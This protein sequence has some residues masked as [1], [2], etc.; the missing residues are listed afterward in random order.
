VPLLCPSGGAARLEYEGATIP[1]ADTGDGVFSAAFE[2][3]DGGA[4]R[5]VVDCAGSTRGYD[6][7]TVSL[8]YNGFI[9]NGSAKGPEPTSVRIRGAEVRLFQL[10]PG[11]GWILW[12]GAASFGQTNPQRTGVLG[13][14]GFYPP[15]G[16]YRVQVKKSGF[17]DYI[18]DPVQIT[19][20][21]FMLS[22]GLQHRPRLFLPALN[23]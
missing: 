6:L 12:N 20:Q 22:I 1:L 18:S 14:Y 21:P 10:V 23:A 2:P 4:L 9:Y 3:G 8:E 13:W 17:D 11:S 5:L 7:G 19:T 16:L 15:P